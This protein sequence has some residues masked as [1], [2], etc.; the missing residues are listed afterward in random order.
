MIDNTIKLVQVFTP[1]LL[2]L[3]SGCWAIYKYIDSRRSKDDDVSTAP[4]QG[5]P[6]VAEWTWQD[7]LKS[8][9]SKLEEAI[10][11]EHAFREALVREGVS[12]RR[13]LEEFGLVAPQKVEPPEEGNPQVGERRI[14]LIEAPKTEPEPPSTS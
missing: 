8:V 14:F 10:A 4:V 12:P 13:V 1:I 11:R 2:A 9:R 3:G 6:V 5:Q 7:E